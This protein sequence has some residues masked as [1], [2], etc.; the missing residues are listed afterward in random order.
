MKLNV[1]VLSALLGAAPLAAVAADSLQEVVVE[2]EAIKKLDL[3][4][5][6]A[7]GSRL[8][9]TALETP[10]SLEGISTGDSGATSTIAAGRS[11][12]M[13]GAFVRTD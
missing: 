10:A 1:P 9:L 2:G 12:E 7:T 13:Q 3:N 4:T 5:K 8:G 11:Q 6:S